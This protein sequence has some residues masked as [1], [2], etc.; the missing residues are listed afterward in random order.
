MLRPVAL[1]RAGWWPILLELV[2]LFGSIIDGQACTNWTTGIDS[3]TGQ[4][5]NPVN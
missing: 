4:F 3:F 1:G 5:I 2:W